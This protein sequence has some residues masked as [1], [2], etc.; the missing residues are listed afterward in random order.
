M[1][2]VAIPQLTLSELHRG[3]VESRQP[4]PSGAHSA[5]CVPFGDSHT[6]KLTSRR[7]TKQRSGARSGPM[8]TG[9]A[10]IHIGISAASFFIGL[11]MT[12]V[13]GAPYQAEFTWPRPTSPQVIAQL[14]DFKPTLVSSAS[15]DEVRDIADWAWATAYADALPH[16]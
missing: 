7:T 10:R 14:A 13:T 3:P 16:V 12:A 1:S 4:V 9:S 8:A 11:L 6:G 5:G 2:N 15:M